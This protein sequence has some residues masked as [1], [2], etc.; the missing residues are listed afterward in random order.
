MRFSQL[1][2]ALQQGEAG[3]QEHHLGIRSELRRSGLFRQGRS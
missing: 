2:A 1:I 3:L